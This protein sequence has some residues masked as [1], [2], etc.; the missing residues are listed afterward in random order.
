MECELCGRKTDSLVKIEIEQTTL[1][2]CRS[3]AKHG[4]GYQEPTYRNRRELTKNI[5]HESKFN[6]EKQLVENY[7]SLIRNARQRKNLTLSE[8]ARQ[9][10]ETESYL[11]RVEKERTIPEEKVIK[12]LEKFLG[13][14]LYEEPKEEQ[15]IEPKK[16][17]L[18]KTLGDF[19]EE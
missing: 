13:I 10:N 3:C 2:V 4:K 12:K 18:D 16:A 5:K 11:D 6:V 19:L 15:K 14:A 8:L 1:E 17:S 9:I 7:G